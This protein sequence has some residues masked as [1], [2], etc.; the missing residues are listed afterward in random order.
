MRADI[1]E[2][3]ACRIACRVVGADAGSP[4]RI[5]NG[6]SRAARRRAATRAQR[7]ER[8]AS[9]SAQTRTSN[10]RAAVRIDRRIR[11]ET[12]VEIERDAFA[13]RAQDRA[14]SVSARPDHSAAHGAR[15]GDDREGRARRNDSIARA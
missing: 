11:E 10:L 3:V 4:K 1:A 6:A 2:I 8:R 5:A 7:V 12:A 13:A 15:G 14:R 9:P